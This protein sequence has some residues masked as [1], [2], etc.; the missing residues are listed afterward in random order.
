VTENA[1][2]TRI[3]SYLLGEL[4]DIEREA[5]EERFFA[6]DE[7]F[8]ELEAAEMML[9]D[10]YV[11][12]QMSTAEREKMEQNYLVTPERRAKVVDAKAF[13][14]E[15]KTL[16]VPT[17]VQENAK[18][19]WYER[20]FGGL[21]LSF[22]AM[23]LAGASAIVILTLAVGW[24]F[25]DSMRLR[26][27][28]LVARNEQA[29]TENSLRNRQ[30][31]Q[32]ERELQDKISAQNS[33]SET[34]NTLEDEVEQLKHDLEEARKKVP[35]NNA[36]N[37]EGQRT[38]LIATVFLI[39]ARGGNVPTQIDLVKGIK[40]LNLKIPVNPSDGSMFEI[41]ITGDSGVILDSGGVAPRAIQGGRLLS[42]NIPAEKMHEGFYQVLTR[43]EKGEERT[44]SF[45]IRPK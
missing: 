41:K 7:F 18:A 35:A 28:V 11:R 29:E 26:Q 32:K 31:E 1:E 15:L 27:E 12:N 24:L 8:N 21:G 34:V 30:L 44:R 40:I 14:N 16:R 45:V 37:P 36:E 25:Y 42:I 38:P 3:D 33:S 6:D 39:G 4:S 9:I 23:Q 19:S 2:K 5:L 20:L 13:H 22:S 17:V 43:N 10:R